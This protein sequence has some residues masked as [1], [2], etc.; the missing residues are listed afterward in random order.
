MFGS[1]RPNPSNQFE[2]PTQTTTLRLCTAAHYMSGQG[3]LQMDAAAAVFH[4]PPAVL[5]TVT[6][7][8]LTHHKPFV[9]VV[10]M[11]F[12]RELV[13]PFV[14]E[15]CNRL[16]AKPCYTRPRLPLLWMHWLSRVFTHTATIY[17]VCSQCRR[18]GRP[19]TNEIHEHH[20]Y[21]H[22]ADL[23]SPPSYRTELP[24]NSI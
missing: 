15:R 10:N 20:H 9:P 7:I 23:S 22:E 11:V 12:T 13:I 5:Y 24:T 18:K 21:F 19:D 4:A 3:Q 2:T 14:C 17:D 6:L 1:F 8:N 16:R